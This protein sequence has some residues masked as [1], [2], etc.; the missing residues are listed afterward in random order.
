VPGSDG[1][2]EVVLD[3]IRDGGADG[4][5]GSQRLRDQREALPAGIAVTRRSS[6]SASSRR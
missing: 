3:L 5:R 1:K 6:V 4:V 2:A